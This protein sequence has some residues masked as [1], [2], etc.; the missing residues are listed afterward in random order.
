MGYS[1][2]MGF[3]WVRDNPFKF[4][5]GP[6]RANPLLTHG[7]VKRTMPIVTHGKLIWDFNEVN[8]LTH[9]KP[10]WIPGGF[11][12]D[13]SMV[14][15]Y[16]PMD[17]DEDDPFKTHMGFTWVLNGSSRLLWV[18]HGLTCSDPEWVFWCKTH[19]KPMKN[20]LWVLSGHN[21][22]THLK[23]E[24]D[25]LGLA[26]WVGPRRK[27]TFSGIILTAHSGSVRGQKIHGP[28]DIGHRPT[29]SNTLSWRVQ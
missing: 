1:A 19:S 25:P 22:L 11:G 10:M 15:Y 23:P 26:I 5:L 18:N 3:A 13:G 2:S 14:G 9:P 20:P 29:I 24:R 28:L 17:E 7:E 16:G 8:C 21:G 6:I 27:S 12:M 4:H